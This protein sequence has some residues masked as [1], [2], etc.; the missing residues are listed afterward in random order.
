MIRPEPYRPGAY[1]FPGQGQAVHE[2]F[3]LTDDPK[4]VRST[5]PALTRLAPALATAGAQYE[6]FGQNSNTVLGCMLRASDLHRDSFQAFRSD[7][8]LRLRL[9][10]IG[11]PLWSQPLQ[12]VAD[13]RCR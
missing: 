13:A 11:S 8:L 7:P 9:I 10:G 3:R 12:R 4:I 6:L 5:G 2:L 1:D